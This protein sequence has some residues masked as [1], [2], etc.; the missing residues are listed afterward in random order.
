MPIDTSLI[1]K[2]IEQLTPMEIAE[3]QSM[4]KQRMVDLD[5]AQKRIVE[6]AQGKAFQMIA[7]AAKLAAKE[8]GWIKYPNLTLTANE[9]GNDFTVA[10]VAVKLP[11]TGGSRKTSATGTDTTGTRAAS[12]PDKDK[13]T[14]TKINRGR[15]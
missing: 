6:A 11:R 4:L 2:P 12:T 9:A 10:Y 3:Q 15:R 5:A 14:I 8:L 13:I 1:G 7:D